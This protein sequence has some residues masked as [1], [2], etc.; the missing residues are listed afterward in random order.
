MARTAQDYIALA[1]D[2]FEAGFSSEAARKRAQEAL[3][4]GYDRLRDAAHDA[5]IKA[6]NSNPALAN[7]GENRA[8]FFDKNDLPFNLHQLRDRHFAILAAWGDDADMARDMLALRAAIK[9]APIAKH[10]RPASEP[11]AEAIRADIYKTMQDRKAQYARALDL[12]KHFGGLPVSANIHLVHG[13]KG[14]IFLR[15]FYYLAGELTPLNII[16]AAA[17][18]MAREAKGA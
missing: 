4:R 17:D 16:I 3:G 13:H 11:R 7:N 9:A 12:A 2:A 6:A 1:T 18:T 8:A 14:A 15:A 5:Q 10:E